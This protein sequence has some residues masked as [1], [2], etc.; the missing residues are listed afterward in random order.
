MG[1]LNYTTSI[2]TEKTVNEIQSA[3]AKAGARAVLHEYDGFGHVAA[4]SFRIQ[5]QFGEIAFRLPANIEAVKRIL[6]KQ[7]LTGKIPRRYADDIDQATRTAWRILKDWLLAQ[8]ALIETGMATVEQ[9]F[10]PYAQNASGLTLY[11]ALIEKKFAGLA[12]PAPKD[13][14]VVRLQEAGA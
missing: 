8:S 1:L 10:L 9:V 7:A 3:L 4:L 6:K 12:L 14:K 13:S 2:S 11:E 5:T